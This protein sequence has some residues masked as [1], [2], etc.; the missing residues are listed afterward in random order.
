MGPA[1]TNPGRVA[2]VTHGFFPTVG[3]S[4]RYHLF[5]ARGLD[6]AAIVEVFTADLNLDPAARGS[7]LSQ[8]R[9][10]GSIP[11][12]YLPSSWVGSERLVRP[13][14]LWGA[15]RSFDPD[16][17]WGN[18]PSLTADLGAVFALLTRRPWIATYHADV[19]LG[20]RRNRW[21]ARW[22]AALLRRARR[23]LVTSE[24]YR[25]LLT[26]RGVPAGRIT[27]VPTGPYIGD[28]VP[29]SVPDRE[30]GAAPDAPFLFVGALDQGHAYKRLDLLLGALALLAR[31]QLPVS[32]EVVG[33]GERRREFETMARTMGL[34]GRVRFLGHLS[35]EALAERLAGARALILPATSSAEG[36]GTA[37]I[38]A[39][40]YGCPVVV[41]RSVSVGALLAE[42]P[43]AL[44]FDGEDPDHLA[45][46]L[47]RLMTEPALRR[48]LSE[49]AL[50][51]A[52]RYRWEQLMPRI[53]SVVEELLPASV[54]VGAP[55]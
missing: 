33:D 7:S 29:P 23:I 45:Q 51:T 22:E 49:G 40:Q 44:V 26:A 42:G 19:S 5:G 38:E 8:R 13:S 43:A 17:V 30:A 14:A 2:V 4:E 20:S 50:A 53:R 39:I 10:V 9:T 15:L 37:A 12:H 55:G 3:G 25:A 28:G 41:H 31:E 36:F 54:A 52:P 16:V 18:H 27:V 6:G 21:Y 24:A 46:P 32:L 48:A 1:G 35:D 34:A 47:R 11:V